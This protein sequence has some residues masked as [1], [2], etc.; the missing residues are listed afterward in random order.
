VAVPEEPAAAPVAGPVD[1][2]QVLLPGSR[3][4]TRLTCLWLVRRACTGLLFAGVAVGILISAAENDAAYLEVDTSSAD[5]VLKGILTSFG[6][7]FASIV[8]RLLTGWVALAF[9]YPVAREHQGQQPARERFVKRM[10]SYVD[11]YAIC[12]A[13]RELRWTDGVRAA[14][15]RRLGDAAPRYE[16]LDHAVGIA[17]VVTGLLCVP[18]FLLFGLTIRM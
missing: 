3:D 15:R 11:R 18:A 2:E 10:S 13:F 12:R 4:A 6:L 17:N 14:A 5:S 9:A 1:P 16:R 7:V 8:L